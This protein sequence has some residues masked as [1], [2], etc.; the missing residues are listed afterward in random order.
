MRRAQEV[1]EFL[2]RLVLL[3]SRRGWPG[4]SGFLRWLGPCRDRYRLRQRRCV[5]LLRRLPFEDRSQ[6]WLLC[7]KWVLLKCIASVQLWIS[8]RRL[9]REDQRVR[10]F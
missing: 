5:F 2:S 10:P 6:R 3:E 4:V 1:H 7:R 8:P 9:V